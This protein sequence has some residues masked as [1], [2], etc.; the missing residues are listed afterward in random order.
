MTVETVLSSIKLIDTDTHVQEPPDLWTSRVPAEYVDRVPTMRFDEE[1]GCDMWYLRDVRLLA[2]GST[3]FAGHDEYPPFGPKRFTDIPAELWDPKSRL[4]TM[5]EFGIHAQVLY[6]NIATFASRNFV[7]GDDAEIHDLCIEVYNDFLTE[8]SSI[9]PDRF[10]PMAA[11]PFW[12]IDKSVAEL[13]RCRAAGHRGFLFTQDPSAFG[14]PGLFSQHWDPIWSAAQ[15]MGMAVNFH[16]GTAIGPEKEAIGVKK[17]HV[18]TE[19]LGIH[20][21]YAMATVPVVLANANTLSMLTAGGVCHRFPRLNF[22]LVESGVGW[23][24]YVLDL[25]DWQWK[26]AGAFKEHPERMLPSEYFQRQIYGSFWFEDRTAIFA[27]EQFADN[28]LF[29]TDFPHPI[30]LWPGPASPAPHPRDHLALV[31]AGFDDKTVRKVLHDNAARV[32][33]I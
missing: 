5:D 6:P 24:P 26:G 16:I 14:L 22:V 15:E 30:N 33:N 3:A 20:A 32:Y 28:V 18:G 8:F 17:E 21:A 10:L 12:D 2:P 4:A 25:L 29:E 7:F 13:E 1:L 19:E 23:L 9:A 11:V 27:I 31:F